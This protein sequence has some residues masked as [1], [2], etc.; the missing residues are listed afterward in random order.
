MWRPTTALFE[1]ELKF[2]SRDPAVFDL[3]KQGVHSVV[4]QLIRTGE[5]I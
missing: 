2:S 4:V 3:H 5:K 1:A